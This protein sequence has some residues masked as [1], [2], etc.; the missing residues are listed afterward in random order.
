MSFSLL[1][2]GPTALAALAADIPIMKA[3]S[4]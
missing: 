2:L 4:L 3:F 1:R